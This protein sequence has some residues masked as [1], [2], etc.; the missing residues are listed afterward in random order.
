[1]DVLM[2]KD[3]TIGG[4]MRTSADPQPVP[5]YFS[6]PDITFA[7]KYHHPRM[8]GQMPFIRSM[9]LMMRTIHDCQLEYIKYGKPSTASFNYAT[10]V[11]EQQAKER[12]V[13]ITNVYMLGDNPQGDIVGANRANIKSILV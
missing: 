1:M 3:G 12:E 6:N 2:S 10:E 9:E 13:D 7:D 5:L 11:V 8:S 4:P